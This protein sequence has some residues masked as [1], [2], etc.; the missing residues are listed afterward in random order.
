MLSR[1]LHGHDYLV[2]LGD[3]CELV[4][5]TLQAVPSAASS[6]QVHASKD[7]ALPRTIGRKCRERS[8]CWLVLHVSMSRDRHVTMNNRAWD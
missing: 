1:G 7:V 4:R 8:N 5:H 6:R 2:K 3:F